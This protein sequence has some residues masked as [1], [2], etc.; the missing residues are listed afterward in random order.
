MSDTHAGLD[1]RIRTARA[2]GDRLGEAAARSE[3][4]SLHAQAEAWTDGAQEMHWAARLAA[5]AGHTGFRGQYLYGKG[6][7]L[8]Q[9][10]PSLRGQALAA[11]RQAS[12][13]ARV[14]G[15]RG[16]AQQSLRLQ[17][18][19]YA[20]VDRWD[21]AAET[22][23]E[24]VE[25]L[26]RL[27][28]GPELADLL[29][30]RA[31]FLRRGPHGERESLRCLERSAKLGLTL[32]HRGRALQARLEHHLLSAKLG[33][34]V[35]PI[36]TRF[37]EGD[38]QGLFQ[39]CGSLELDEPEDALEPAEKARVA[40]LKDGN[41]ARYLGSCLI[42]AEALERL[43]RRRDVLET[44]LT[45]R[46]TLQEQRGHE[47]AFAARDALDVLKRRWGEEA[48]RSALTEYRASVAE[49]SG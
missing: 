7:L 48:M 28:P 44:L 42:L 27:G 17:V 5:D 26:E 19:L 29:R 24:L 15:N 45:C 41:A 31:G 1:E 20:Q 32:G 6:A 2:S 37:G 40:A 16:V 8:A 38:G 9:A 11:L 43:G 47:A 21:K 34:D 12:A 33:E 49:I 23:A 13:A 18:K 22:A 30:T 4:A 46:A 39:A 25:L 14:A 36:N 35:P 10:G 3:K